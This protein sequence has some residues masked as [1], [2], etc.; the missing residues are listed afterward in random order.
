MSI[1][2]TSGRIERLLGLMSYL[3]EAAHP[4]YV[5]A[6]HATIEFASPKG[7]NPPLDPASVKVRSLAAR[8]GTPERQQ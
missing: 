2:S 6:P 5:L 8:Q 1:R 7:P 4:Y 3:P